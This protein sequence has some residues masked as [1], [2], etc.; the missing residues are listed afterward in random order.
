MP[1]RLVGLLLL[2]AAP[3][4]GVAAD[5]VPAEVVALQDRMKKLIDAA[6]PS[7]VSL[8]IS[9]NTKHTIPNSSKPWELGEYNSPQVG[10]FR[11]R[12]PER[13]KLDLSDPKNAGDYTVGSGVVLDADQGLVL[14]CYHL[15]DGARKIY[16]R[17]PGNTGSYADIVAG[18]ARSDLVVLRLRNRSAKLTAAKVGEVRTHDTPKNKATVTRGQWVVSLAHPFAAG[19]ADG[20]ASASWG[21]VSNIARKSA[22]P[23]GAE[24]IRPGYLYQYG[25]LIQTDA[26]LNL[27]CSGGG[28]FNLDGELIGLTSSTAGVAGSESAGGFA[29]PM[30]GIYRGII[31]ALKTGEEVEYGFLGVEP[32]KMTGLENRNGL[33]I[34]NVTPG[35]PAANVGIQPHDIVLAVNGR[36]LQEEADLFL[37]VGGALAGREVTLTILRDNQRLEFRPRLAKFQHPY[38]HIASVRPPS[39][40]G[41]RVDYS[42]LMAQQMIGPGIRFGLNWNGVIV[43]ELEPNSRAEAAFRQLA[44]GQGRWLI[45]KVNGAPTTTPAGFYAA[46]KKSQVLKLTVV[47][48]MD[49]SADEKVVTLP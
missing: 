19:L 37:L 22:V 48:A 44:L 2:L 49:P 33:H 21:I 13:D 46:A 29:I 4:V 6:E 39:F 47:N 26:R 16:A 14:T 45:T 31:D 5:P 35:S 23:A 42:S 3:G 25:S 15:I 20:Q 41:L 40:H 11:F 12:Q 18:D 1:R 36:P 24:D 8:V 34:R 9:H 17:L 27:G 28:L 38:P 10:N 7:V 30:D 32:G 43:R